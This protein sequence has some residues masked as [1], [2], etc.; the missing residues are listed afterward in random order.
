MS[1]KNDDFFIEK[2]PWSIV[3]DEL[4]G[5]YLTPYVSK[6]LHTHRPLVYVDCFAGKGK[7]ED[8]TP[9]SPIIAMDIFKNALS[10]TKIKGD[11]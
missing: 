10:T 11:V 7:F 2:K 4:L 8:G 6:I 3:K 1:K 5:C 9:G